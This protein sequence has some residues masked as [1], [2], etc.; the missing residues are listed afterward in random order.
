MLSDEYYDYNP[1][2][3]LTRYEAYMINPHLV[4]N[5]WASASTE[6]LAISQL[7]KKDELAHSVAQEVSFE[8]MGRAKAIVQ[9]MIDRVVK[10]VMSI[11]D[12]I[13]NFISGAHYKSMSDRAKAV[14][15]YMKHK[16]SPSVKADGGEL[17]RSIYSHD[18]AFRTSFERALENLNGYLQNPFDDMDDFWYTFRHD[19]L[20]ISIAHTISKRAKVEGIMNPAKLEKFVSVINKVL[21]DAKSYDWMSFQDPDFKFKSVD[22]IRF[23]LGDHELFGD[24]AAEFNK[25]ADLLRKVLDTP[26]VTLSESIMIYDTSRNT[27]YIFLANKI[28]PNCLKGMRVAAKHVK[29]LETSFRRVSNVATP[30]DIAAVERMQA[31]VNMIGAIS[32]YIGNI[33]NLISRIDGYNAAMMMVMRYLNPEWLAKHIKDR[34][35]LA[36]GKAEVDTQTFN[37]MMREDGIFE[38]AVESGVITPSVEAEMR[39][40]SDNYVKACAIE[41]RIMAYGVSIKDAVALE[42]MS[43]GCFKEQITDMFDYRPSSR[44]VEV[45]LEIGNLIKAVMVS[46]LVTIIVKYLNQLIEFVTKKFNEAR[47]KRVSVTLDQFNQSIK[48]RINNADSHDRNQDVMAGL[49]KQRNIDKTGGTNPSGHSHNSAI[50]AK[51][52]VVTD[53]NDAVDVSARRNLYKNVLVPLFKIDANSQTGMEGLTDVRDFLRFLESTGVQGPAILGNDPLNAVNR[54]VQT[55]D[56][57]MTTTRE[58]VR[59]IQDIQR[60]VDSLIAGTSQNL[61]IPPDYIPAFRNYIPNGFTGNATAVAKEVRERMLMDGRTKPLTGSTLFRSPEIVEKTTRAALTFKD[62]IAAGSLRRLQS[63]LKQAA[64]GAQ[65]SL[66]RYK[67]AET[68]PGRLQDVQQQVEAVIGAV[69]GNVEALGAQIELVSKVM[70]YGEALANACNIFIKG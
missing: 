10:F 64:D 28:L 6:A 12:R 17:F 16:T 2:V 11:A 26:S 46:A 53:Q 47:K 52:M 50:K 4:V 7:F 33:A 1:R 15:L 59:G 23:E 49:N 29:S 39:E 43:P 56:Q 9:S 31:F 13:Q 3:K 58:L 35:I 45:A 62:D 70:Y 36:G 68:D 40:Y 30:A 5:D 48:I 24:N 63:E 27:Q 60:Q 57:A 34:G 69:R 54:L 18:E 20:P 42:Q 25:T 19:P 41:S 61:T 21:E 66:D 38:L 22:E 32:S 37:L 55:S 65:R 8:D 67:Q 14:E 44:N 51:P